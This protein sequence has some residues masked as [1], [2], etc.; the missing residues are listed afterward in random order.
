EAAAVVGDF[1]EDA[2]R[3][4]R[5]ARDD[6][7]LAA[8]A[9]GHLPGQQIDVT[10]RGYRRGGVLNEVDDYILEPRVIHINQ[11]KTIGGLEGQLD[12]RVAQLL[13]PHRDRT[14]DDAV[15][16]LPSTRRGIAAGKG[17]QVA[18]D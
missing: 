16:L 18:D 3:F 11:G 15:D 10:P 6:P 5:H 8:R 1:N 9:I 14:P 4:P 17:Q 2:I 13:L 7:D 12:T